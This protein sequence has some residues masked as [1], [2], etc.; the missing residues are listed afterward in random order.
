MD[1][2]ETL[3]GWNPDGGSGALEWALGAAVL[4][5]VAAVFW[6]PRLRVLL[7]RVGLTRLPATRRP[8]GRSSRFA[9]GREG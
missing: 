9:V 2:F 3:F 8:A 1:F 6:L 5:G 4:L 7:R